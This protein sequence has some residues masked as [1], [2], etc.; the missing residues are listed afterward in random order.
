MDWDNHD[1]PTVVIDLT[2]YASGREGKT[3]EAKEHSLNGKTALVTGGS[4]G[5]GKAIVEALLSEGMSVW[6]TSRNWAAARGAEEA[7]RRAAAGAAGTYHPFRCDN[8]DP[9]AIR[10]LFSSM[11]RSC[12]ALELLVNNAGIGLFAP[13]LEVE[14]E[15]WERVMDVNARGTFLM[16]QAAFGWMK[17]SGGGRIINIA[18]AVGI[19]GYANQAVYTA[20]KHAVMGI[21]RALAREG[22][23]W[24]IRV[25]AVCPGGVDTELI[26]R[27]RPDLKPAELI[28]PADVARSVLYLAR[29]PETCCTDLI[30][31]R[32]ASSTPFG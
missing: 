31:L 22:Q 2:H 1:Q 6:T 5:I 11:R 4:R 28:Q 27:A 8:A 20:S 26:S 18:S 14:V 10:R 29:E 24:G 32:R 25:S 19:K 7:F 15:Q 17:E 9:Q 13:A 21:T 3:V 12:P 16:S 30:Q 23:P